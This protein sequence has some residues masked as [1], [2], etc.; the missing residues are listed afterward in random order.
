MMEFML[1][2]FQVDS[3]DDEKV[4]AA[5]TNSI[6]HE[7]ACVECGGDEHLIPCAECPSVYHLE[8]H[9]PPLRHPPR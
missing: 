8:C 6:V 9:D 2:N 3:E 1:E 4:K 5:K 7:E